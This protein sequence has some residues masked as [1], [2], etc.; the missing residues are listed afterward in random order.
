M[1]RLPAMVDAL[2]AIDG[3]ERVVIDNIAR[4]VREAGFIQTTKRGRGAAEMTSSD[5]A[6]L[7]VGLYGSAGMLDAPRVL[8]AMTRTRPLIKP[9]LSTVPAPLRPLARSRTA[10]DS[11]ARLIE[12]G[13]YMQPFGE[14]MFGRG[15]GV[16]QCHLSLSLRRPDISASLEVFWQTDSA[17]LNVS[18]VWYDTKVQA[19][20]VYSVATEVRQ[21]VFLT[22]H[23]AL[24][25]E[26]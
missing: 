10:L 21:P 2:V 7:V 23:R 18:M 25:P 14:G 1:A 9:D 26:A 19:A 22:L 20:S 5:A 11:V 13:P 4:A 3:R 24:T 6:A 17:C 8:E 16:G 15:I 12:L